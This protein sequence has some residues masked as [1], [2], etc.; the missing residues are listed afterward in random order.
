MSNQAWCDLNSRGDTLNLHDFCHNPKCKCQNQI[1][2][3]PRH[4]QVEGAGFKNTRKKFFDGTEEVWNN[5][6]DPGLKI[7]TPFISAGVAA[8]THNRLKYLVRF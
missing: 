8:K 6:F 7:A 1:T 5:F 3:T 4:F 2:F